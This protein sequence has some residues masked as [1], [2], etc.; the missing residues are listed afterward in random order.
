[1]NYLGLFR[2]YFVSCIACNVCPVLTDLV[3]SRHDS[4][5]GRSA[6]RKAAIYIGQHKENKRKQNSM[7]RVGFKPTTPVFERVDTFQ[8]LDCKATAIGLIT[9]QMRSI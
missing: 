6:R 5:D 1:M 7:L 9:G 4:L 3:N 8:A 2:Q